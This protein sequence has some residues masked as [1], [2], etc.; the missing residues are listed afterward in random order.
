[1]EEGQASTR[2]PKDTV[3]RPSPHFTI[4][5]NTQTKTTGV[6]VCVVHICVHVC[7]YACLHVCLG[8]GAPNPAWGSQRF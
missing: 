4:K 3:V 2:G 5:A 6:H 1:M 7:V 8:L